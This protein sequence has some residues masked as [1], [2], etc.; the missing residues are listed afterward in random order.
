MRKIASGNALL[1]PAKVLEE[2]N[3]GYGSVVAD[4]GTGAQGYFALQAAKTVGDRGMVYA[5][6][7]LKSA[8]SSLDVRA[9]LAGL[10]NIKTVWTNLE[11]IGGAKAIP[12]TSI[13]TALIINMLFQ[14]N[15]KKDLVLKE[16][17]RMV[18]HGGKLIIIDWK[19]RGSPMGPPLAHRI[20]KES[21]I[22]VAEGAGFVVDHEFEPGE[23]HWGVVF[24]KP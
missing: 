14:S 2:A 22:E 17:F 1:N 16:T 24:N 5:A 19:K 11:I 21:V 15:A 6:D 4:L 23:H 10:H 7:I 3:V 13:D 20:S 18:K 9:K 8:L 12:S